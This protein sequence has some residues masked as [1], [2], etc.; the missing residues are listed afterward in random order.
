MAIEQ[1]LGYYY[2]DVD[3]V[4]CQPLDGCFERNQGRD[5]TACKEDL[6]ILASDVSVQAFI[7]GGHVAVNDDGVPVVTHLGFRCSGSVV[8][9]AYDFG[10]ATTDTCGKRQFTN[11]IV[12]Y[13]CVP[14]AE[15][16]R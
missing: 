9:V 8:A 3:S 13:A 4:V 11:G 10:V 14:L 7:L 16:Y 1:R 6:A 2:R 15:A 5:A 12:A